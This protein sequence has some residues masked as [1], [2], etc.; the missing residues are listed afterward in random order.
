MK[1]PTKKQLA[2]MELASKRKADQVKKLVLKARKL[3]VSLHKWDPNGACS[4]SVA[5]A[6]IDLE[7]AVENIDGVGMETP[8]AIADI[9]K[10]D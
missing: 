7:Q 6:V 3:A 8:K 2:A 1:T 9:L 4:H 10:E 5:C